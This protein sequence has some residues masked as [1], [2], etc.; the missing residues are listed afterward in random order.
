MKILVT[1]SS[2]TIG[3]RLCEKLLENGHEVVGTD[4]KPNK[5]QSAVDDITINV[6]LRDG[7]QLDKLPTDIDTVIHL[8]AN[9][10]VYELVKEPDMAR[11]NFLSTYNTL[12]FA[13]KN[14]IKR[15]IFTSSRETYG[16]DTNDP[17]TED[18]MRV[19]NCESAYT[20]SKI[21][22]EAL[23]KAYWRCYGIDGIVFRLSN[24]YG[25]Y[26][27][28]DRVI[29]L[30]IRQAQANETL[31]IFGKEKCLDF[32]YIDDTVSGIMLA[33]DKFE[34][35]KNQTIN[36]AFGSATTLVRLAEV[37]KEL[38]G[39][40][41]EMKISDNRPGE[42]VQYIADIS[43]AQK[44]LGY[45]PKTSFDEGIKKSVEWYGANT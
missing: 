27:D 18:M 13:R 7:A 14:N 21:G 12:E 10:R 39:S 23:M 19:D 15:F 34:D 8:A 40:N 2:G 25:M 42:V 28:S 37:V 41:S 38:L 31:T 4:W 17:H 32:T 29:P 43:K 16:N 24:V 3:T 11:D 20:A 9:A 26:D 44:L 22:G 45:A 5:W 35:A 33:L 6:D 1:G 30:F 36:L